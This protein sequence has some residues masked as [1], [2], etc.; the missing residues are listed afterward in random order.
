V[1][2][3]Y[4]VGKKV[5]NSSQTTLTLKYFGYD[6]LG[7]SHVAGLKFLYTLWMLD[8]WFCWIPY[9]G[10][11]CEMPFFPFIGSFLILY[12]KCYLLSRSPIWRA[13]SPPPFTCLNEGAPPLIYPFAPSISKLLLYWGIKP[14]QAQRP[15][16]P[17][18]SSKAILSLICH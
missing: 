7:E 10:R 13:I 3:L 1:S 9:N 15:N 18:M 6:L 17:L 4:P 16:I 2:A 5:C 12:Y 11:E 14:P 8:W